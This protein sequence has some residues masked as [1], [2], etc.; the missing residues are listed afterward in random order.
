VS[1]YRIVL[2]LDGS[3]DGPADAVLGYARPDTTVP[4]VVE[5]FRRLA[6]ERAAAG[7]P[8]RLAVE[9]QADAAEVGR[10]DRPWRR[11]LW[12]APGGL[13]EEAHLRKLHDD[14]R[15]RAAA[16]RLARRQPA[17]KGGRR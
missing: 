9:F 2:V 11:F 4:Q 7:H 14:W 13:P 16:D 8:G 5:E 17:K 1:R 10:A 6:R 12:H 3:R 15:A